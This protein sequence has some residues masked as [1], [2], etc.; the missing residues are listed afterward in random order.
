MSPGSQSASRVQGVV[1]MCHRPK[2]LPLGSTAFISPLI[3]RMVTED[4]L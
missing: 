1:Y 2:P 3:Q 4:L